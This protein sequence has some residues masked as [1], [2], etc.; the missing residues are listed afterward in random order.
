MTYGFVQDGE[1]VYV[2]TIVSENESVFGNEEA[3]EIAASFKTI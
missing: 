3:L 1:Q 2:I